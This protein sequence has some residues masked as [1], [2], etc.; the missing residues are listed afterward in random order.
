VSDNDK[1]DWRDDSATLF[2]SARRAHDPTPA[3]RAAF[4]RV[5]TRI[6]DAAPPSAPTGSGPA[7]HGATS[8]KL[9]QIAK[10]S[11]AVLGVVGAYFAFGRA[12]SAPLA[13]APAAVTA[14]T[15]SPTPPPSAAPI[16]LQPTRV[17]RREHES[18]TP[19][20]TRRSRASAGP[21]R[22]SKRAVAIVAEAPSSTPDDRAAS[23]PQHSTTN[24]VASA[25]APARRESSLESNVQPAVAPATDPA[26]AA[27]QEA[28]TELAVASTELAV[29]KRM[30]A[31]LRADD[32]T[33]ALAL[34]AEHRRRWPHG[35]FELE[36]E[37]VHAIAACG[38]S[39]DDAVPLAKA[40][41]AKHPRAAV[42]MRV[43]AACGIQLQQGR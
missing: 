39:S 21:Q 8:A 34:C 37:G 29:L 33:T 7:S 4:D 40:F 13:S 26:I 19:E 28:S 22:P 6:Q 35:T 25:R 24:T 18:P 31:A 16:D 17:A 30:Q 5:L 9:V 10:V 43:S 38:V 36:R 1:D 42:A 2:R 41:L 12:D 11:L 15:A 14:G 32:F 23:A 20:N 27:P 3:D